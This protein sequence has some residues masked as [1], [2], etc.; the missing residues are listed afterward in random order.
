MKG[1]NR[2]SLNKAVCGVEAALTDDLLDQGE[3]CSENRVAR[4]VS[5]AGIAVQIGCKRRLG[6]Y[7]GKLTIVADVRHILSCLTFQFSSLMIAARSSSKRRSISP[8]RLSA[9]RFFCEPFR[10]QGGAC[11]AKLSSV[12]AKFEEFVEN[13]L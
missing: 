2:I 11:R 7:G 8:L 12:K 10:G 5:L 4:L 9:E 3:T 1:R 13:L 6:Q